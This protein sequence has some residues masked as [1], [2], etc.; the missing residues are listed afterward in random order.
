MKS[1][2]KYLLAILALTLVLCAGCGNTAEK[3]FTLGEFKENHFT[4]NYFGLSLHTPKDWIPVSE[5]EIAEIRDAGADVL[6]KDNEKK[7]SE[8]REKSEKSSFVLFMQRMKKIESKEMNALNPSVSLIAENLTPLK[9]V[10]SGEDYLN[11]IMSQ[12]KK[13]DQGVYKYSDLKSVD[14]NGTTWYHYD[15][16]IPLTDDIA[17]HLGNYAVVKKGYILYVATSYLD[18][19]GDKETA[20]FINSI[21]F[22]K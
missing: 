11:V 19:L 2:K 12:F 7:K 21:K 17:F 5:D 13:A 16:Y 18:G 10:E 20:D 6:Y 15:A 9:S 22:E 1:L 14:I 3:E 4:N 8:L